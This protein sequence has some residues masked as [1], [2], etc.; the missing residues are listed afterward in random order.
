MYNLKSTKKNLVFQCMTYSI[1]VS[2]ALY[3]QLLNV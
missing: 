1:E 2:L 3:I